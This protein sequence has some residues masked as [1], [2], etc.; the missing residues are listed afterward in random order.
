MLEA[1]PFYDSIVN[2][3]G[4]SNASDTLA[5]LRTVSTKDILDAVDQLPGIFSY[6]AHSLTWSPRTDGELIKYDPVP[7]FDQGLYAHVPVIIGDCEDEGT[8][9][10]FLV[11]TALEG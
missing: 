5:C 6:S 10:F 1:Q 7:T 4:C 8:C 3:T 11:S 9:V 2:S